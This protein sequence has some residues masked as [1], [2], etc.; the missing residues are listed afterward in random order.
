M[1]SLLA[2]AASALA[3]SNL[4]D[5]V[6][7]LLRGVPGLPPVVQALHIGAIVVL[8]SAFLVPQLKI[9]GIAASGQSYP[10]MTARLRPWAWAAL[11]TLLVTGAVFV[12]ARPER[13]FFNPVAGAKLV[14]VI[15]ALGTTLLTQRL[16]LRRQGRFAVPERL[17]AAAAV[18][19]WCG[20]ILAGRWIAYVDYL[21]W[22][23]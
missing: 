20:V 16:A 8:V 19:C 6:V 12:I 11:A 4:R 18:L 23:G 2:A 1:E 5:A 9:L 10:E 14:F 15:A 3:D 17:L 22:E 7:T 13:Y 21:F